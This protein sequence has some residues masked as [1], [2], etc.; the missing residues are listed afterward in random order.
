VRAPVNSVLLRV[1]ETNERVVQ[2]GT[3]IMLLADPSW[4][5]V[6]ID[7]LSTDA[8]K[9]SPGMRVSVEDW[10]GSSPIQAKVRVVEPGAFTK[11]SA[12]GVEEQRV[13]VIA[14]LIDLPGRLNDGYRVQGRIVIW[15]R[16]D[17]LSLPIGALFRCGEDWCVFAVKHGRAMRQFVHVG[18]RNEEAAQ[19][20]DGLRE[21]DIVIVYPPSTLTDNAR[22][23]SR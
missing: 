21:H 9:I 4:Y 15:E 13:Y 16:S 23:Q 17:V 12:L 3:P 1:D 5:E 22:V 10:G 6:R 7:V 2:A 14:D 8:V 18:Q 20:I 11:V 19:V